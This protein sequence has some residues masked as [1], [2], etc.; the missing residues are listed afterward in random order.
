MINF[1]VYFFHIF[2]THICLIYFYIQKLLQKCEYDIE[3][4]FEAKADLIG[5][6]NRDLSNGNTDLGISRRLIP[7]A[8]QEPDKMLVCESGIKGREE[9]DE[10]EKIG[11]HAFL[12]G[13]TLMKS[14]DIPKKL[15]EL[16]NNG[17]PTSKS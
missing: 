6:N 12:I 2:L 11:A 5:I 14:N 7:L 16:V 13:E 9:I 1:F 3:K 10:F 17:E 4:A 8:L 15:T